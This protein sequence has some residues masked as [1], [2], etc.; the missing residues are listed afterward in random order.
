MHHSTAQKDRVRVCCCWRLVPAS[1]CTQHDFGMQL[2]CKLFAIAQRC[3]E[4]PAHNQPNTPHTTPVPLPGLLPPASPAASASAPLRAAAAQLPGCGEVG[5]D[6]GSEPG[7]A[8][9]A[10]PVMRLMLVTSSS[11]S[12]SCSTRLRNDG[13]TDRRNT[14]GMRLSASTEPVV[15]L[16]DTIAECTTA[17][18]VQ[19]CVQP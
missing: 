18:R 10:A 3:P 12:D 8:Q 6:A 4:C 5:T 2:N 16:S 7:I 17:Q 9:F 14:Y 15:L 1:S 11:Q 19:L 13:L